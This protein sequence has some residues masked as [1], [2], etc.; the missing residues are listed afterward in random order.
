MRTCFVH[1][2]WLFI[3][4][5]WRTAWFCFK[6]NFASESLDAMGNFYHGLVG[7]ILTVNLVREM[8]EWGK[9]PT[10]NANSKIL[11]TL[12]CFLFT[13]LG[14]GLV[15]YMAIDCLYSL[16]GGPPSLA[17]RKS[18]KW[19]FRYNGMSLSGAGGGDSHCSPGDLA[20]FLTVDLSE[21]LG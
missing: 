3:F 18:L 12:F 20:S 9:I 21:G 2:H 6:E 5:L 4:S 13:G 8:F 14:W 10:D 16:Y 7:G 17:L 19:N 1:G 11:A 15:S